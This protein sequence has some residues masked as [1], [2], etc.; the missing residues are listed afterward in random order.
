M[1]S[2]TLHLVSYENV[3]MQSMYENRENQGFVMV[4]AGRTVRLRVCPLRE[5]LL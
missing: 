4:S 5:F 1:V 2:V 3:K